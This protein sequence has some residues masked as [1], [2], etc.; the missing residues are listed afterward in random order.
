[1]NKHVPVPGIDSPDFPRDLVGKREYRTSEARSGCSTRD[2][3]R[4]TA[5]QQFVRT[6]MSPLTPYRSLLLKHGTG[7]GKTCAAVQAAELQSNGRKTVVIVPSSVQGGFESNIYSWERA[8]GERSAFE[9]SRYQCTGASYYSKEYEGMA[10]GA[11]RK[12]ARARIRKMYEFYGHDAFGNFVDRVY[13][14]IDRNYA[15]EAAEIEKRTVL[16]EIFDNRMFI[17]D[18][19]HSLRS[20][21]GKESKRAYSAL[22]DVLKACRGIRLILLTATPMFNRAPEIVDLV[23]LMLANEDAPE[24]NEK[25]VFSGDQL[26]AAGEKRLRRALAGRV[27]DASHEDGTFPV[28]LTPSQA[29]AFSPVKP[30]QPK[31][32]KNGQII[33]ASERLPAS[34]ELFCSRLGPEQMRAYERTSATSAMSEGQQIEN[35]CYDGGWPETN[36]AAF[37]RAFKPVGARFAY[38]DPKKRYLSPARVDE[39][40]PKIGAVVRLVS[41]AKGTCFVYSHFKWSGVYA[42]AVALEEAGFVPY[43]GDTLLVDAPAAGSRTAPRYIVITNDDESDESASVTD[44]VAALNDPSQRIKAILGTD[45]ASQGLDFKQI[46][47][48]HVLEPW[49]NMS[50]MRQVTGRGIRRCSHASLSPAMNNTT[51]Y[52]HCTVTG[53]DRETHD[54]RVY[55]TAFLKNAAIERVEAV[56][57]DVAVDCGLYPAGPGSK[58]LEMESSQGVK[59]TA[60]RRDAPKRQCAVKWPADR[61]DRSTLHPYVYQNTVDLMAWEVI[62]AL[63][64]LRAA[65]FAEVKAALGDPDPVALSLSL[66]ALMNPVFAWRWLPSRVVVQRNSIYAIVAAG[67]AKARF[68]LREAA[69]GKRFGDEDRVPI[70]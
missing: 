58:P 18:E 14:T 5:A 16:R 23:N 30:R 67:S 20:S 57:G 63:E 47:E 36:E 41:S 9:S 12:A 25:D 59:V 31:L 44:K 46:R 7:M 42:A 43:K 10:P 69:R 39:H 1:M 53:D 54:Q 37:R 62:D 56:I 26:T 17:V 61:S 29:G 11:V 50:K 65:T 2:V 66:T 68:T 3:R 35:V 6:Y 64:V 21:D 55:R 49:W 22:R 52:F 60:K 8:S 48:V 45:T 33:P 28:T 38:A 70:R 24:L 15:G 40:A 32:Q 51:V 13:R 27:S 19:A 4:L 34:P